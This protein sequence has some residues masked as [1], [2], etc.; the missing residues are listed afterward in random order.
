MEGNR[1]NQVQ[2]F[3]WVREGH[4]PNWSLLDESSEEEQNAGI[5]RMRRADLDDVRKLQQD[6]ET[7]L[8]G[9]LARLLPESRIEQ[10]L[11]PDAS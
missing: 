9:I 11:Q 10:G 4:S 7:T 3:D 6:D 5:K 1:Y 8:E 2:D